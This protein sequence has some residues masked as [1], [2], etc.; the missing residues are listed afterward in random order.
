MRAR[1]RT[2]APTSTITWETTAKTNVFRSAVRNWL[3]PT[4]SA[5]FLSPTKFRVR[6]PAVMSL[7]L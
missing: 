2:F 4:M 3:V 5:K 1:A 7:T 6:L